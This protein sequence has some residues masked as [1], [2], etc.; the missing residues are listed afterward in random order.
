MPVVTSFSGIVFHAHGNDTRLILAV[1]TPPFLV[2]LAGQVSCRFS[3]VI[4][5]VLGFTLKL[6]ASEGIQMI[7]NYSITK[8]VLV[9]IVILN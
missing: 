2:N 7:S 4:I 3:D 9:I 8:L 5:H 6:L 1:C